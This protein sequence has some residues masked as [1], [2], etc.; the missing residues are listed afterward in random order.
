MD[1]AAGA[2]AWLQSLTRKDAI[3]LARSLLTRV[4]DL[5]VRNAAPKS[6]TT[7]NKMIWDKSTQTQSLL[8]TDELPGSGST[9]DLKVRLEH[10]DEENA[11]LQLELVQAAKQRLLDSSSI[12][13]AIV[14]TL[15]KDGKADV[16]VR[17]SDNNS[18]SA[19]Q[20][21][22][23]LQV[24]LQHSL[25]GLATV[26]I[27]AGAD[28]ECADGDGNT[29][30]HHACQTA[31]LG[32]VE[33][34]IKNGAD[35]CAVNGRGES[36][37]HIAC[38]ATPADVPAPSVFKKM[39]AAGVINAESE[40]LLSSRSTSGV[41]SG[42]MQ[43]V[44]LICSVA[45]FLI[46]FSNCDGDSA[47]HLAIKKERDLK[48][49]SLC[50]E[51]VSAL[52]ANGADA[53]AADNMGV[54]PVQ[55]A[56]Q[57]RV[58]RVADMLVTQGRSPFTLLPSPSASRRDPQ[59]RR[60]SAASRTTLLHQAVLEGDLDQVRFVVQQFGQRPDVDLNSL[61]SNG[62]TPLHLAAQRDNTDMVHL[63]SSLGLSVDALTHDGHTALGDAVYFGRAEV[64]KALVGLGSNTT[65]AHHTD[66]AYKQLTA[67]SK[68]PHFPTGMSALLEIAVAR[69][70]W[71]VVRAL[72]E[73]GGNVT[74]LNPADGL[75]LVHQAAATDN[76]EALMCFLAIA[77]ECCNSSSEEGQTPLHV[78]AAGNHSKAAATLISS[79][80]CNIEARDHHGHT[81]LVV[82]CSQ[83]HEAT[84]TVLLTAGANVTATDERGDICLLVAL[85]VCAWECARSLLEHGKADVWADVGRGNTLVHIAAKRAR[86]DILS[87]I[88]QTAIKSTSQSE[89]GHVISAPNNEGETPLRIATQVGCA[90]VCDQLLSYGCEKNQV[91]SDRGWNCLHE[92]CARG[93]RGV[94]EVLLK[95]GVNTHIKDKMGMT[96]L[97]IAVANR[98]FEIAGILA[99]SGSAGDNSSLLHEA[100]KDN[101]TLG[102]MCEPRTRVA[103]QHCT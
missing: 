15:V 33:F 92:A 5:E 11:K 22:M 8:P 100:V 88:Y 10:L 20:G 77:Q 19:T 2:E 16:N 58:W 81:S 86:P 75:S 43:L 84:V 23:C 91:L 6:V 87:F 101:D 32:L 78:A 45:R 12:Y 14:R 40:L 90:E 61:D 47:L 55:T 21:P 41:T 63:L 48:T 36:C 34:L 65:L 50:E 7:S 38:T 73:S 31:D 76:I 82:G 1:D 80:A 24:A 13:E 44:R 95:H 85:N 49:G 29:L 52:L 39:P 83:N 94:V 3:D 72:V 69:R 57:V 71:K 68:S 30:L 98:Q 37:L 66:W 67:S 99:R 27:E 56:M 25:W 42:R 89:F 64:A 53:V 70:N 35:V 102:P 54:L 93:H 97:R 103:T 96:P 79:P 59:A 4:S 26:L 51:L 17:V 18:V 60:A 46:N 74:T 62:V 9:L 28:T